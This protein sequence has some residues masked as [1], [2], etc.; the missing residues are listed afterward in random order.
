MAGLFLARK[1]EAAAMGTRV[2]AVARRVGEPVVAAARFRT[3]RPATGGGD[4]ISVLLGPVS[5][6][7]ARRQEG[8]P[9]RVV[10]AVSET[11]VY[12]LTPR[13]REAGG[14][15]R[16]QLQAS[17]QRSRDRWVLWMNPPGDRHGFE[18]RG[19]Q[20]PATDAV[21]DALRA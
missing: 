8:L 21:V 6:V 3:S 11:R 16:A 9:R 4:W 19:R 12:L 7:M 14:W 17:A 10:V 5:T 15:G 18:V 2:E 1:R 13:G 20:G